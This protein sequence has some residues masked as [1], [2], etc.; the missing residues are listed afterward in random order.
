MVTS[1]HSGSA[2]RRCEIAIGYAIDHRRLLRAESA[3]AIG[4]VLFWYRA[5]DHNACIRR[6]DGRPEI[7]GGI[8][9]YEAARFIHI[10]TRQ[11]NVGCSD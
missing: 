6:R 5:P 4:S 1:W 11:S 8:G 2:L 10:D 7:P 9:I 3:P